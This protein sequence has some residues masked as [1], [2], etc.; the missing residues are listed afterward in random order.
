M[1]RRV[2]FLRV[3]VVGQITFYECA[4]CGNCVIDRLQHRRWHESLRIVEDH[5]SEGDE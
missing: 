3:A 4:V 1:N 2:R 5:Y